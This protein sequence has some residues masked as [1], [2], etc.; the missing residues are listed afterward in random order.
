MGEFADDVYFH[1]LAWEESGEADYNIPYCHSRLYCRGLPRSSIGKLCP[2]CEGTL[3]LRKNYS[4]E[5]EFIGCSNFP[6]CKVSYTIRW[7]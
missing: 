7:L 1:A 2:E 3:V 6:K 5:V 4:T